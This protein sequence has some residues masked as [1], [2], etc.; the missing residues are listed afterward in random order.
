MFSFYFFKRDKK[1]NSIEFVLL[2]I[3]KIDREKKNAES[4]PN[5]NNN[6]NNNKIRGGIG[7]K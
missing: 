7:L 5:N 3:Y 4:K 6:N 2:F 1:Y